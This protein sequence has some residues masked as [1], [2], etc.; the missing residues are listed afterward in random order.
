LCISNF[1]V[2]S[3]FSIEFCSLWVIL[4]YVIFSNN[5]RYILTR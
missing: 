1:F 2:S 3:F 5:I 4:G